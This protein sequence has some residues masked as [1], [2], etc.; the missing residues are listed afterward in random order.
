MVRGK[1]VAHSTLLLTPVG[2]VGRMGVLKGNPKA[3][4][5]H[6]S[7]PI[8]LCRAVVGFFP[9]LT[10]ADPAP[11]HLAKLGLIGA[12]CDSHD[13]KEVFGLLYMSKVGSHWERERVSIFHTA[14]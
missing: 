14:A 13:I 3:C 11:S 5:Q 12:P 6:N 4:T 8:F 2:C 7:S 9:C 10:H 1:E